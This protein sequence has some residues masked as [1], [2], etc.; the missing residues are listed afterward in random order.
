MTI[1]F[2]CRQQDLNRERR[3]YARALQRRGVRLV[4]A[5]EGFPLNGDIRAL[6]ERCPE[7][8]SL[9]IQPETV[10]PLLPWGLN[11]I[12]IPTACFQIDTYAYIH[13]RVRWSMLFDYTILFHP[14]FEARFRCAGH[15]RP[16]TLPHAV[17]AE[18]FQGPEQERIFEVGWVGRT[19]GPLYRTRRQILKLLSQHFRMNEW[20]RPHTYE[21]MAEVYKR[22]KVVVNI[23]RDDYPQDAPL[24]FAE[25]MAAGALFITRL[26][27]E[28]TSLGFEEG[29]HFVGYRDE[30]RLLDLVHY[31]LK[32][33]TERQR[34]A[35]AG[36]EKVLREHTYDC[37]V[38]TLLQMLERD[39][40]QFFAPARHWSEERVRL[41]YLDWWT[42]HMYLDNALTE[43]RQIARR[44]LKTALRGCLL[45]ARAWAR[46]WRC[47]LSRSLRD[48]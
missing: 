40:G 17:D 48:L 8:P 44:S 2:L 6:L 31:Y 12:D 38:E 27:T 42:A 30:R 19:D 46:Q 39:K 35:E 29:K 22:S 3:G 16:V 1:L 37:R 21:E 15:P 43:L 25:A 11:E 5:D 9:I 14:G 26:P 33:E 36:R 7:K 45:I 18:V 13:R 24:R 41:V 47:C 34:I 32:H 4:C 20:W 10:F 23:A 28:L